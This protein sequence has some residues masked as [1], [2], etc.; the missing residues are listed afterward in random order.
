MSGEERTHEAIKDYER[1]ADASIES[2]RAFHQ[3]EYDEF[4]QKLRVS[5][6]SITTACDAAQESIVRI[7][8]DHSILPKLGDMSS[9]M[10]RGDTGF[11]RKTAKLEK[12]MKAKERALDAAFDLKV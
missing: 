11:M 5:R 10:K 2:L 9:E 3:K 6:E 7:T 8:T 12:A 4:M 1:S